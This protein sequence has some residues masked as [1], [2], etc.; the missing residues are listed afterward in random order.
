MKHIVGFFF[1]CFLSLFQKV[2]IQGGD[3]KYI[4]E[5]KYKFLGFMSCYITF[6]EDKNNSHT[7]ENS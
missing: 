7:W 5:I 2:K 3:K 6:T 1:Y 4:A